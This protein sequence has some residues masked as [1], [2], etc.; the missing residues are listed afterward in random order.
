SAGQ[1]QLLSFARA[2]A[3]SPPILVLDEATASID[4]ENEQIIQTS[5]KKISE[6]RTTVIIAHRLSTIKNA[7]K[8]IV[9]HEGEISETGKHEELLKNG[10]IYSKL[11][12]AQ[13]L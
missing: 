9:I 2:V 4:T 10:G 12:E 5:L 3:F 8:I 11:H 7:D 6:N 1:R 13:N